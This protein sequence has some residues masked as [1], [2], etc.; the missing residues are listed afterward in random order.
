MQTPIFSSVEESPPAVHLFSV[1][2]FGAAGDGKTLDTDAI[3]TAVRAAAQW[4]GGTVY[5]PPGN[6]LSYSIQLRDHVT[7]KLDRGACLIAAEPPSPGQGGG[8]DAPEPRELNVYQ[9]FGHSHFRNSLIWGENLRGIGVEGPGMIYGRGLSRGNGRVALPI[10]EVAPQPNGR[11]PDVLEADGEVQLDPAAQGTT[12]GPFGYP[13]GRDTLPAGVGNKAIALAGCREVVIQNLTIL[14]GGHF[15]VLVAQC[16]HVLLDSLLIDTNRDGI[17]VD[18]CSNVRITRCSVN[19]PWDDGICL[20]SSCGAGPARPAE[21]IT[22]SDCYVSGFKE[23]TLLNGTRSRDVPH[24]GGPIGRIKLG[25]EATGGF[26]NIAITNCVFEHCRGLAL[27]Q[28]DGSVLE[29]VVVSNLVMRDVANAPLFLRLGAR[30]R[31]PGASQPG[32]VRRVFITNLVA[33]NVAPEHGIFIAGLNGFPVEDVKLSNVQ[34]YSRGGCGEG[35][36]SR[37]VP[38]LEKD[39]PEPLLFGTLPAWGMYVR[40]AKNISMRDLTLSLMSPD[41]RCAVWLENVSG[42]DLHG[43]QTFGPDPVPSWILRDCEKLCGV[44]QASLPC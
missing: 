25:T 19:S 37:E 15:A 23:G 32:A 42:A 26:R 27:E 43:V 29:D 8:Y 5:F 24:R 28:V 7:L 2:S 33:Y 1:R 3:N 11:L 31:G 17:D 16:D 35:D 39:Y 18:G 34:L 6:Y 40:H 20:K 36:A 44:P 12:P 30:L 13:N 4:G 9:D 10:G 22:I 41:A 14:H 21:N 38:E